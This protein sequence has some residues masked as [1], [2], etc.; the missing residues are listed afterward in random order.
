[1]GSGWIDD[2]GREKRRREKKMGRPSRDGAETAEE[3]EE[4]DGGRRKRPEELMEL[5]ETMLNVV[6]QSSALYHQ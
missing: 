1:M 3:G 5:N 6:A 4:A 2:G